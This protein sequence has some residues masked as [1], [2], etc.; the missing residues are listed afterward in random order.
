MPSPILH[1]APFLWSGAGRVISRLCA[2][3]AAHRPVT[4]VTTGSSEGLTDWPSYRRVVRAA[5]VTHHRLDVFHR[6]PARYWAAVTHLATLLRA[7]RPAVIHAHAGV[8]ASIAALAR[9]QSGVQARLVAQMYSWGPD[10]PG[11][12]DTQDAWAFRQADRVVCSAHAYHALLESHGVP[13]SQMSYLPWG[14]DLAAL[15]FTPRVAGPTL[16]PATG[17]AIGCVGRIEPRKNQVA[18]VEAFARLHRTH[19]RATLTLVGPVADETYA[20]RLTATIRRLRLGAHVRV[21]GQVKDVT[22]L[23]RRWSL[24]V[25]LSSDEGQGLAVLE[26]MALGVPVVATRVAGIEDFLTEGRTGFAIAR[27]GAAGVAHAMAAAL[28]DPQAPAIARRA[29]ALV[30]RDYDWADMVRRFDRLYRA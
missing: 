30:E 19:P 24:F 6:D 14:L 18:L 27:G 11:W 8:P 26:A 29:R 25:S 23:V 21:T 22:R 13:A 9:E 7:L 2:D 15:P 5:G 10:R 16:V 20:R 12:M 17:P 28:A 4:L 3:Q 1:V